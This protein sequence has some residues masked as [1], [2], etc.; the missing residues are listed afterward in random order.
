MKIIKTGA[1]EAFKD[2]P[3]AIEWHLTYNCNYRC[4]YCFIYR[5]GNIPQTPFSTLEQIKT[6]VDN[7]VSLNRPYYDIGLSGGEPTIHPHMF[8]IVELFHKKLGNRLNSI[9]IVTNGSRNAALYEKLAGIAKY[10]NFLMNVSIHTDHV[11]M[12]HI[13]ELIEKLSHDVKMHFVL[14]F[15][16]AKRDMVHEIYETM[17]DTRKRFPFSMNIVL[18]RDKGVDRRYTQE[19]FI[20]QKKASTEF[21][22]LARKFNF[23]T[24]FKK[25]GSAPLH[26]FHEIEENGERKIIPLKNR[27]LNLKNGL[28]NFRGMH[29]ISYANRMA[30][31]ADGICR[32]IVCKFDKPRCNVFDKD[33]FKVVR[34]KLIH[35]VKCRSS[36]CGCAAND[37]IPKF[38]SKEDAK[39]YIE[40][41]KI[42]QAT[43]FDEYDAAQAVKAI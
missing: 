14:M 24:S 4:S 2:L 27:T 21:A 15:N 1:E 42:R 10:I 23:E 32:G 16:P 20:W 38:A 30:I 25:T 17:L 26:I 35:S 12:D 39:K 36:I 28:L 13:L 8:D 33:C 7:I 43:L 22:E 19:D 3:L 6:A 18:I 41:A 5:K 31:S 37:R 40:F 9:S 29:C 34:D 11:E